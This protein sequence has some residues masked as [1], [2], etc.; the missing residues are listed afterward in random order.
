MFALDG[1]DW[2]SWT[3]ADRAAATYL[4]L[5]RQYRSTKNLDAL[6]ELFLLAGDVEAVAALDREKMG[7]TPT[8]ETTM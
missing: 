6:R 3:A 4:L 1:L 2:R 8:I 5:K 7:Q